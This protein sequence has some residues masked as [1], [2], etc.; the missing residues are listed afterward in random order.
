MTWHFCH[1]FHGGL[2]E[3]FFSDDSPPADVDQVGRD[4][5]LLRTIMDCTS[6]LNHDLNMG[7]GNEFCMEYT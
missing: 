6:S 7:K 2:L 1:A 4:A 3:V 5:S